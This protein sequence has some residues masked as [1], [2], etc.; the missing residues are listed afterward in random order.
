MIEVSF[1]C[2]CLPGGECK[3]IF[4]AIA[5]PQDSV[6]HG[7]FGL[8]IVYIQY[9]LPHENLKYSSSFICSTWLRVESLAEG[10]AADAVPPVA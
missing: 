5:L 2:I 7:S 8:S 1:S 9:N 4:K 3:F 6:Y 10:G